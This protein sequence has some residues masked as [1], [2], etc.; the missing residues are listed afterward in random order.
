MA[1]HT[2]PLPPDALRLPR[3]PWRV[4]VALTLAVAAAHLA[5]LALAPSGLEI[6]AAPSDNRFSTRTITLE[7]PKPPEPAAAPAPQAT[8]PRPTAAVAPA[9]APRPPRPRAVRPPPP[10]ATA[11]PPATTAAAEPSPAALASE[12]AAQPPTPGDAGDRADATSAAAGAG[13]GASGGTGTGAG[14]I[15]GTAAGAAPAAPA[16]PMRVPG[17]IRLTFAVTAQR[18]PQPLTG[19]FG[20]LIWNQN[21]DRYEAQLSAKLLFVVLTRWLSTGSIGP[22]GIAP[23]RYA[24][25]RRTPVAAH[26]VRDRN[27]IVF[28]NNSPTVPLLAGAQDRL[29]VLMQL[30][31][32]FVAAPGRYPPGSKIAVQTVSTK[33]ADVW[34]FEVGETET[35]QLPAGEVQA[36][37]LTRPPRRPFDLKVDLWLSPAPNYLPARLVLTETNGDFADFQMRDLPPVPPP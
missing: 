17:S 35:L 13:V 5:L 2:A 30:G 21:G 18:G 15:N 33:E 29:S 34:T 12:P 36:I 9:P 6:T 7:P 37:R 4:I 10:S 3:S 25:T 28:S 23:D 27:E 16:P 1:A 24:D 31:G 11:A 32:L 22:D 19:A 14:G 20:E 26:F 8:A